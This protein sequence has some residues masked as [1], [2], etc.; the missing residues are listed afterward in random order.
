MLAF[1]S[2]PIFSR[3]FDALTRQAELTVD[4]LDAA[5]AVVLSVRGHVPTAAT[6]IWLIALGDTIR[7][8][9]MQQSQRALEGLLQA[10]VAFGWGHARG[11]H[12]KNAGGPDSRRRRSG[13]TPGRTPVDGVVL[14][15]QATVDQKLLTGESTPA[16]KSAGY[17]IYAATVLREG[18]LCVQTAKVD[19][20]TAAS[21]MVQLVHEA[22]IHDTRMQ[23]YAEHFANRLV[24]WS[25]VGAGVSSLI[26]A[27][28]N[29]A[30]SLLI[31]D[32]GTGMR[33]SAPRWCS[34]R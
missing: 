28:V 19:H 17:L 3:A 12:G 9:T 30:A 13:H 4:I 23:N 27:N 21:K 32:Y 14:R 5:A 16:Q 1:A 33:M 2:V 6:M 24:P 25:F 26:Q 18:T 11:S 7:D 34:V 15:E 31:I 8:L 22:P 29:T 20:E 10:D